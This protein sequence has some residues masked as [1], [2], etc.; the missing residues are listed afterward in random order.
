M[1]IC[2]L[3]TGRAYN[4][5]AQAYQ[6]FFRTL[7]HFC[8][9]S[10]GRV[11]FR[12]FDIVLLFNGFNPFWRRYPQTVIAE[13]QSLSTGQFRRLKDV[14]K[15]LLNK[16]GQIVIAQSDYV[17]RGMFFRMS[18]RTVIRPMGYF[19]EAKQ[20]EI[21]KRYDIVYSGSER[22][23]L[24]EFIVKFDRMGL[25]VLML[26]NFDHFCFTNVTTL[27]QAHPKEVP[28]L[29]DQAT[30]GLN[31]VP[32]QSPYIYQDSTKVIEYAAR[33]LGI[34]S[35]SYPWIDHFFKDR[36]GRYLNIDHATNLHV[37]RDF[38]Y[39]QPRVSDLAWP[40][41]LDNCGLVEALEKL[42]HTNSVKNRGLL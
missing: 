36:G 33:G 16:R 24:R 39:A 10:S 4:P 41:L 17:L 12:F 15:R 14:T 40:T 26:G 30:C 27:P 38:R 42:S 28:A 1:K 37:I 8:S 6:D 9:I 25:K 3:T 23:G 34:I 20:H 29:L 31:F 5:E 22:P 2:I 18:E 19:P 13:Y 11:D 7:G 32:A 21:V 35:N